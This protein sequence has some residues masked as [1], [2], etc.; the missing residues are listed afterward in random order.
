MKF[1]KVSSI[2]LS[3][4]LAL[5]GITQIFAADAEQYALAD[6]GKDE[7]FVNCKVNA[8]TNPVEVGGRMGRMS[9]KGQGQ[10]HIYVNVAD[11]FM[12]DLP[13]GTPVEVTVEY[14]DRGTGMFTLDYDSHDYNAGG[15]A[16]VGCSDIVKLTNTEEWKSYTFH[17]EDMWMVNKI[18][19]GCDFRIG[20]WGIEMGTSTDDVIFGSIKVEYADFL[21]LTETK[22]DS[23]RYGNIFSSDDEIK[24]N[25]NLKN[26]TAKAVV[27][28]Y[29]YKL[30]DA[31]NALLA[32]KSGELKLEPHEEKTGEL[33]FENP[34]TKGLY[35]LKIT[36][37]EYYEDTPDDVRV[38]EFSE[39]FSI[40]YLI[41]KEDRNPY[42]GIAQQIFD[43]RGDADI[44]TKI[45][46]G[47]G[48]TWMRDDF[49][50]NT[51]E[52][53]NGTF[54]MNEGELE[55]IKT[56]KENGINLLFV[57]GRYTNLPSGSKAPATDEE[58]AKY[59]EFCG[60]AAK[61]LKGYVDHFEIWNEYN[62]KT[63]NNANL[64][65]EQYAKMLKAAYP[66]IKAAN[67]DA[68]VIGIDTAD[69][70]LQ[71]IKRVFE[72]GAYDYCDY[73]SVHPYD[74]TKDFREGRMIKLAG[75]LKELMSQYG[76][77]KPVWATEIGF[78]TYTGDTG[79]T[80]I[81]QAAASVRMNTVNRAYGLYDVITQYS[82]H[83]RARP[84]HQEYNWGLV[85]SW[86]DPNLP[87][88]G[89]K[90]S[91]LAMAAHN[92]FCGADTVVKNKDADIEARWYAVDFY[93]ERIGKDALIL[94]AAG[95]PVV[96]SYK[97]GCKS[98]ELYDLYGN[99][100]ST[101]VSDDGV[102][103]FPMNKVP[104]YAVG[105]FTSF[106]KTDAKGT[107]VADS[108]RKVCSPDDEIE[109]NFTLMDRSKNL[110]LSVEEING[111]TVKENKGFINGKAKI[112]LETSAEVS[113]ELSV[114]INASD[115]NGNTYYSTK[116]VLEIEAPISINV[117]SEEAV[118]G[119]KTHWKAT[120]EVTNV[121]QARQ[122]NGTVSVTG[123]ADVS[124]ICKPREFKNLAP[125]KSITFIFN[126]PERIVKPTVDLEITTVLS[127]GLSYKNTSTMD[128]ATAV[129]AENKPVI[130]G[131]A[132]PGEWI[133]SWVGA[134]EKKDIRE[135]D[136]WKG[137]E[138]LS[139]SGTVM[140]DEDTFYLMSIVTDDIYSTVYTPNEPRYSYRGDN[141][142][143]GLDERLEIN[144]AETSDINELSMGS[145]RGWGDFVFRHNSYHGL[146]KNVL[147]ENVDIC[148]KRYDTYT[149]YEAA[150]PFEEI[151]YEGFEIDTS[152]P[153]RFSVMINENDGIA[154]KGWI[155]YTS[156][157]GSYKDV[158]E[159]G[160]IRFIK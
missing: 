133:G 37:T 126:L 120:V 98:L 143:F 41:D 13:D 54:A 80:R 88:N 151:F 32:E 5:S 134:R 68:V 145:L 148:I 136:K 118:P 156:G 9:K 111:V 102:Y 23:E 51:H 81:G 99:K 75:E 2:I 70:D 18:S 66:A 39:G 109:F 83:D 46:S 150:I 144:A 149:V 100:M 48:I 79:Y 14:F 61:E 24:I 92:Y 105:S 117:K 76:E 115:E 42:Y 59:A 139:F 17:I 91:Y 4:S 1:K 58:I 130:D 146:D 108:V 138:D 116:H 22:V 62:I 53:P 40:S 35:S 127:N 57:L 142:Q 124:V 65:P 128:F 64:P 25:H 69:V 157:I 153:Y 154:R 112:I 107:I 87:D 101:L 56:M 19:R 12:H 160:T 86:S 55:K 152:R 72:A 29:D 7:T 103:T 129:Y 97:L 104:Y 28:K 122:L 132:S 93:N 110:S 96:N 34:K 137:P 140:W 125:G 38:Q 155:Q 11:S 36:Q 49:K 78:S 67:P 82:F 85:N 94:M 16:N 114:T 73:I 26:K 95:E 113:G 71:W 8:F 123:P 10:H 84:E 30:Y 131:I 21:Y 158:S 159:F 77:M 31:N 106:E 141:I 89:A 15:Y 6:F 20:T 147:V 50:W 60:W 63:F 47:A 45:M 44:S 90:E 33:I 3:L 119:S 52:Q 43:G 27:S 74:W 121:S 135:N